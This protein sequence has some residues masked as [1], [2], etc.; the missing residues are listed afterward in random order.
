MSTNS[1]K[2]K[3]DNRT[4]G[5]AL[6]GGGHRATLFGLGALLYLA[7]SGCNKDVTTIAS[8]S[9]G[10][11]TNAYLS[12]MDK[13][14]SDVSGEGFDENAAILARSIAGHRGWWFITWILYVSFFAL[15][16][17]LPANWEIHLTWDARLLAFA[18]LVLLW[19][20]FIGPRSGGSLWSW[21]GMWLYVG[22]L[23][24]S[25]VAVVAVW[26]LPLEWGWCLLILVA[27]FIAASQR[28]VIAGLAFG[29]SICALKPSTG[30]TH[31]R[32]R[33]ATP[34][35]DINRKIQHV[36]CATE[37]HAGTHAYFSQDFVYSRGF[38]V[39]R[40]EGLPLRTVVQASANFPGG[41]PLRVLRTS[42]FKFELPEAIAK[43]SK[44]MI[45]SDG[46]VFDNMADA[47]H[48]DSL[49]RF[50]R[51]HRQYSKIEKMEFDKW[52]KK[53]IAEFGAEEF[54]RMYPK[55]SV[56]VPDFQD[57][58]YK[59]YGDLLNRIIKFNQIPDQLIVINGAAPFLWQTMRRVWFPVVG[60]LPSF[61]KVTN[62]MYNNSTSARA[63]ELR[64]RF[65]E[66]K[67]AGAVVA[68]G[69][70]PHLSG[71]TM[72]NL[73]DAFKS[74][75]ISRDQKLRGYCVSKYLSR[76]SPFKDL[77]AKHMS[78]WEIS[79]RSTNVPTT[80]NPLGMTQTTHLLYHGYLQAMTSLY[81][82]LDY[83]LMHPL[84]RLKD[85]VPLARGLKRAIR[86]K[87]ISDNLE[88]QLRQK[89]GR[90]K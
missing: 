44:W 23:L 76:A 62:V 78:S 89:L 39:G 46:G 57:G 20:V 54:R 30:E 17:P 1:K 53:I 63:R 65:R 51:L 21:W 6:S 40:P 45:L 7:D 80:L 28:N 68:I 72:R 13:P 34:L 55:P 33:P 49:D 9:G 41:F 86:P 19:A 87:P 27:W 85:F 26:W 52:E 66:Q 32:T 90:K 31:E 24:P 75:N 10:S 73:D 22:I 79:S 15:W 5:I 29:H 60:E 4:V 81:V 64:I 11:L 18:V 67:P 84:P 74:Q 35:E 2:I 12:L 56:Y 58:F 77:E 3:T 71:G 83:P 59:K 25:F 14:F 47:W 43:T 42:R 36:F 69:E 38:G 8:V 37:M 48:M 50:D 70:H 88:E 82:M 61:V 16:L